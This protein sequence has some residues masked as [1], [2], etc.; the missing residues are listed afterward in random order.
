MNTTLNGLIAI[1]NT[2]ASISREGDFV[3]LLKYSA[4]DF[5]FKVLAE[6][7]SI[8]AGFGE[9]RSPAADLYRQR[10]AQLRKH[11]NAA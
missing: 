8:C 6:L 4:K 10:L 5:L 3:D 1:G 7:K 2:T 11:L 9:V